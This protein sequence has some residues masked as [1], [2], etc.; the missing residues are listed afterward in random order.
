MLAGSGDNGYG[1]LLTPYGPNSGK[2][3]K[4]TLI[5]ALPFVKDIQLISDKFET[6]SFDGIF[7]RTKIPLEG[8]RFMRTQARRKHF[9]LMQVPL[10]MQVS[11]QSLHQR[12]TRPDCS[13]SMLLPL[14]TVQMVQVQQTRKNGD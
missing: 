5:E 4:I 12:P 9:R 13:A 7:R 10:Q 2:S 11:L 1:G 14:P 6:T 3:D 8:F